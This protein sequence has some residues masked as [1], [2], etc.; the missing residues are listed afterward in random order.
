MAATATYG[1]LPFDEAIAYLRDKVPMPSKRWEDFTAGMHAKAFMVAGAAK[2]GL[3][4]DMHSA[5][6]RGLTEGTGIGQFRKDFDQIV[7]KHGWQYKGNRAWRTSTIFNT[8]LSTA[9][10]AGREKQINDP[11]VLKAF[12]YWRYRTMDDSRVRSLHRQWNN[13]VLPANDPWWDTHTPP[14]GW[15]CRCFKEPVSRSFANEVKDSPT[16]RTT[17]P[18]DGERPWTNPA[19]GATE[20]IPN[21]IDPGWNYNPGKAKG[22]GAQLSE[23]AMAG[24]K[25][26]GAKAWDRLTPGDAASHNRPKQIPVDMPVAKPGPRAETIEDAQ[27]LI[28]R[29]IGGPE[30][31]YV[32]PEEDFSHT[33]YANAATLA[34]HIDLN[35]APAIPYITEAMDDPFEIWAS[36]ERHKGTGE[37]VLR[38]RVIKAINSDHKGIL[39]AFTARNGIMESWTMIPTKTDYL[40]RQRVGKLIWKR[41][42]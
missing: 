41:K 21:G 26:Q 14:N 11:D 25:K 27:R 34:H 3:L 33:L 22:W 40:N 16:F 12:P 6:L 8:N 28:E 42:E 19:T 7:A 9:Y 24:W 2:T 35:R 5:V 18:D 13:T 36:F 1:S 29:A 37:V 30:K 38:E 15:N 39:M 31:T 10:A 23:E 4:V 32:F 20:M 17:A